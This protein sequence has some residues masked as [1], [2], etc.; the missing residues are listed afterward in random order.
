MPQLGVVVAV[1]HDDRVLLTK[2][3]DFEVWCLPGGAVDPHE[4][5]DKAAIRE[6]FEETG[7]RIQLT[8]FVGLLSKPFW[9]RQG[10]HL[11]VFAARP[12][13]ITLNADP[14][15]VGALGFFPVDQLPEPILWD[16]RQLIAAAQAGATGHVW[17]NRARTPPH[18]ADRTELY[19]W[20]DKSGLSREEAYRQLM[21]GIGPQTLEVMLGPDQ[22]TQIRE[23]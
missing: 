22:G 21:Q 20:R 19:A 12:L 2:R 6:V 23:E 18:F 11:S 13:S 3:E 8:H 4:A 17:V 14:A 1:L 16:H 10:T 7:V 15:E 9:G 5:V